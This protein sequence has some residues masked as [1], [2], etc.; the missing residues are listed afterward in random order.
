[1]K[2]TPNI[3]IQPLHLF[4]GKT[5]PMY[6]SVNTL[7]V[8]AHYASLMGLDK[9]ALLKGSGIKI[10]D[11]DDPDVLVT[12]DQEISVMRNI[13]KLVPDPKVG[14]IIGLHYHIG[15]IGKI[16]A[17]ASSSDT[18]LDAIRLLFQFTEL[19]MTYFHFDLTVKDNL[20][21]VRMDELV[22]E[23][24][25][26]RFMCERELASI[27]RISSDVIGI[28]VRY[29]EIRLAYPKPSYASYYKEFFQCPVEF[30]ADAHLLVFDSKHLFR[31]LPMANPLTRKIYEKECRQ[32]SLRIKKQETI[33]KR[34]HQEILFHQDGIPNFDQLARYMNMSRRT[35]S[36][37]LVE[38][39]TSYRDLLSGILKKKAVHLLQ[40]TTMPI[41]QIA[42]ELGYHDLANFYRAF[43]RWTGHNPGSYRRKNHITDNVNKF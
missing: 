36:R 32:L 10:R 35:L 4:S 11:L 23:K 22:S 34:I 3:Q 2:Q 27:Y 24:D 42:T 40:T 12:P 19:M 37:R 25:I 41:E 8:L 17:A 9:T 20:A 13:V 1:M 33:A 39:G 28:P 5:L 38:E 21:F 26:R 6:R 7:A 30:N 16:G 31:Q 29:R 18:L 14:L 15:V 43:K